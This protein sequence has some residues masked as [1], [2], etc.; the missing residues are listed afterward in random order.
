MKKHPEIA[1]AAQQQ[2]A[3][4][5]EA[6]VGGKEGQIRRRR[7]RV[8]KRRG[9]QGASGSAPAGTTD[10]E[11]EV[12]AELPAPASEDQSLQ[13]CFIDHSAKIARAEEDLCKALSVAIVRDSVT[14]PVDVLA[15][16]LARRYELLVDS[17]QFH[18]LDHG[19]YLLILADEEAAL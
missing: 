13:R 8:Q 10:E 15:A 1:A 4:A 16:E 17:L 11:H 2:T 18:R 19:V 14:S 7:R 12:R 3:A 5:V 6:G 9:S